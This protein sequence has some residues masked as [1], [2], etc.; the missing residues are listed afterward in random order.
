MAS[1]AMTETIFFIAAALVATTVVGVL[2]NVVQDISRSTAVRGRALAE[3]LRTDIAII[4]DPGAVATSPLTVYAKNTGLAPL[5]TNLTN[6][7]VNGSVQTNLTFDVLGSSDD[8]AWPSGEVLKITVNGVSLPSGDHRV[9][10]V[11]S[12]GIR[13]EMEFTKA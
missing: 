1:G 6:V 12:N 8:T 13:A 7:L 11:T 3:E 4:N 2:G 5:T 9:R 10:V